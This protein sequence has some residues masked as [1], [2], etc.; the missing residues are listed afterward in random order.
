MAQVRHPP[1]PPMT[2]GNIRDLAVRGLIAFGIA[3]LLL[4]SCAEGLLSP[5]ETPGKYDLLDCAGI[6]SR[7]NAATVKE[8]ELTQLMSRANES[9]TGPIVNTFVYGDELNKA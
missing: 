7:L 2:L 9:A 8:K 5:Y 6:V 1:G 4:S 3:G